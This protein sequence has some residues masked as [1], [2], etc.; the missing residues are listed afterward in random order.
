MTIQRMNKIIYYFALDP[1]LSN[2]DI[3]KLLCVSGSIITHWRKLLPAEMAR[4]V[5][6]ELAINAYGIAAGKAA[7]L[8]MRE[9][10]PGFPINLP[11][12]EAQD[13]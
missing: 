5:V 11:A 1:P 7:L 8:P 13:A 6:K 3:A 12:R 10:R 9:D 4:N 2:I